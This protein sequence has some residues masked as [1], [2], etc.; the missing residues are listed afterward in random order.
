G[1][2]RPLRFLAS[3]PGLTAVSTV[4]LALGL[5]V[6]TAI[7]SL[8]REMLLRPL[9]YQDPERLVRVFE[10]SRSL[11][12]ANAVVVPGNFAI[13]RDRVEALETAAAFRRVTFNVS[14]QTNAVQVEGFLTT[15]EF[16]PMLGVST[17]LGRG[18]GNREGERGGDAVVLLTDGF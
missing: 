6:N 16:F 1:L 7:F 13:W 11:G 10:S 18:F 2:P 8:T 9:P 15:P 12:V 4:T 17:A 3:H 5:G 14:Y